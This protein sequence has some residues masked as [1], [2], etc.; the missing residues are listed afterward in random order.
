MLALL[1]FV[2]ATH[3][4]QLQISQVFPELPVDRL[5]SVAHD[6]TLG[7][8]VV[9]GANGALAVSD[10]GLNFSPKLSGSLS[11]LRGAAASANRLV[12][13]SSGGEI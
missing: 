4:G 7:L 2:A 5:Y 13:A 9:A 12:V 1:T 11:T 3:V 10:D 8:Y 6:P